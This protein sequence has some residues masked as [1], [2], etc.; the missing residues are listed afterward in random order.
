MNDTEDV[1][2]MTEEE[3]KEALSDIIGKGEDKPLFFSEPLIMKDESLYDIFS[4]KDFKEG[5]KAGNEI[6]GMFT[7]LVNCGIAYSDCIDLVMNY[8]TMKH[9]KKLQEII[10]DGTSEVA[11]K[12][13]RA[14][15][16][17]AL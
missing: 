10:N 13:K 17:T 3:L 4:N 7:I 11:E 15:D 9:N 6:V 12:T 2:E 14:I 5:Q 1:V 8:Q 16:K